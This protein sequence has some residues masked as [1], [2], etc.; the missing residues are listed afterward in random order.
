[1]DAI[2]RE[3]LNV[4]KH[5]YPEL[6][7]NPRGGILSALQPQCQAGQKCLSGPVLN[8]EIGRL[9]YSKHNWQ[10]RPTHGASL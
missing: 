5:Q 7:H 6:L 2:L 9:E 3:P 4:L 1:M 10:V 8:L